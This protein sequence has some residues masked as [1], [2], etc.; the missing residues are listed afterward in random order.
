MSLRNRFILPFALSILAVLAG[1]G[2]NGT[3]ATPPPSGGFSN[4]N[5]S[6]T[7][8]ISTAGIDVNNAFLT[9]SGTITANGSGGITGGTLD[10]NDADT[11][12]GA[13]FQLFST[14]IRSGNYSITADGRGKVNIE[15]TTLGTFTFAFVLSSDS[16]G[17]ITEFDGSGSGS[18]T[19]DVQSATV[20]QAQLAQAYAFQL[21]GQDINQNSALVAGAFTLGADGTVTSGTGVYDLNDSETVL[22]EQS[23]SGSMT[24]GSGGGSGTGQLQTA[25]GNLDF[26]FYVIDA[27]HLKIIQTDPLPNTV[28][29]GDLFQQAAMPSGT[30]VFSMAG[31]NGTGPFAAGGFMTASGAGVGSSGLEDV[32]NAGTVPGVQVPFTLSYSATT[33]GRATLGLGG[34]SGG[35]TSLA[36]YP[37]SGGLLMLDIDGAALASGVAFVQTTNALATP[38]QGY[39]LNFSGANFAQG[40]PFQIDD[41]AEFVTATGGT[42]TGILDENDQGTPQQP[43]TITNTSVFQQDS[44]VTGRGEAQFNSG[45]SFTYATIDFYTVDGTNT[46]FIDIDPTQVAVG[47][48]QM[49]SGT[50][51]PGAARPRPLTMVRMPV[52][53]GAKHFKPAVKK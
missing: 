43:Q 14:A 44:P 19:I 3:K 26:N 30:L 37:T 50:A 12:L 16:H 52:I 27:T 41:I 48:F 11:G 15:T 49:Q 9:T 42:M 8:V 2:S 22:P 31:V 17:L 4:S 32:N 23:L 53:H 20:T 38:P 46:I 29:S 1:C 24:L 36:V 35:P 6:G 13:A 28:L 7:Y 25:L 47:S 45:T 39:G 10:V 33:N 40:S 51:T 18:G 34:F 21:S 5:L